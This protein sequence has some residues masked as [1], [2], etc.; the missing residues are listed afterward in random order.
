MKIIILVAIFLSSALIP[1][2]ASAADVTQLVFS[3]ASS[4]K[5]STPNLRITVMKQ[6][7]RDP[8][9]NTEMQGF[10]LEAGSTYNY[11]LTKSTTFP[12]TALYTALQIEVDADTSMK[13]NSET[14]YK[15]LLGGE[16]RT[17]VLK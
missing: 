11:Y 8:Y 16:T 14:A 10:A 7:R 5:T 17:F 9:R 6:M 13:V 1:F 2:N 3:Q 15:K 4:A 12:I